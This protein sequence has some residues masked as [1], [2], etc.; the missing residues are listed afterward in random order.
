MYA[1][2]KRS[3]FRARMRSSNSARMYKSNITTEKSC[4]VHMTVFEIL[5]HRNVDNCQWWTY[6]RFQNTQSV[7]SLALCI[8]AQTTHP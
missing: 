6:E 1:R 4:N 3:F 8:L 2:R 7:Q 5:V